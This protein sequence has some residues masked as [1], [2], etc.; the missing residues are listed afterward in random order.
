L[1]VL[2]VHTVS[3]AMLKVKPSLKPFTTCSVLVLPPTVHSVLLK[4]MVLI[5]ILKVVLLLVTP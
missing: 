2:L 3:V 5:L 1:V 4:S